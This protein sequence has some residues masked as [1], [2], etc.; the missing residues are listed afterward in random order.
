M[1]KSF[2]AILVFL[3]ALPLAA[4]EGMWLF[5]RTP[6]AFFKQRYGFEP[7]QAWLDHLQKSSIRFNSGGSG[8]FVSADGLALTNHHVGLDCLAK[9]STKTHDYVTT[10]YH[11]KTQADEV[12]CVDLE[13]NVLQSIEDVTARVNAAVTPGMTT[14][15]AQAARRG[16]MSAIEQ[17]SV[18]KSGLRS[19]VVTLFQG[20]EYHLYQYKKYTDVRLVFAPEVAI[21]FFGGDPDNFE[22]PRYD[23]D[24]CFFRAY[25]NNKPVHPKDY[26]K[27]S[28]AGAKDGDLV[29]VSGHPGSTSRLNTMAHLQFFRDIAYPFT[30][31]L[32][33]RREVLLTNYAQRSI[34]NDR[35]AHDELFGVKNS[36]KA[37]LGRI[38][39]LQDPAV[40]QA[41]NATETALRQKVTADAQLNAAYGDA[42][43]N[44]DGA[45]AAYRPIY[46]EYRFV[47]GG[48]AFNSAL[49]QTAKTLLRLA[50]E[51]TK[52]NGERLREYRESNM[53]SLKQQL[54][55]EAPIYEDLE[56]VTL[57]DSL[58]NWLEVAP[59]DPLVQQVLAGKSPQE[60]ASELVRGTKL[61]DVAARKALGEGGKAV[62]DASHDP[63]I[64]VARIVDGRARELRKQYDDNI[65]EVLRQSYAKIA[66]AQFKTSGGDT[67][68]DATFTLRL[69]YGTVKGFEENGKAVPSSTKIGDTFEH[70][71]DHNNEG[72]F[73]LPKSWMA[74]KEVL[75][76]DKTPY[77][78][79]MTADI[80]GGN[81]GSPVVNRKNEFVGIIFDGNIQSLPWDYQFDE[82]QGRAVAV[83][84][85]GILDALRKVYGVTSLVKELT[86]K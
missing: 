74:K 75:D 54:Y 64:E 34:E 16:V 5:N 37:Y 44:V 76:N 14:A 43:K 18:Q 66:N 9:I 13:L 80:I 21:A 10:G 39:G 69:S 33:R 22:Y 57:A 82:R 46:T 78:F 81:S 2:L 3:L 68:P 12:K 85:A 17:E 20:G 47:E 19:D 56:T 36:R 86:G 27:W 35:R 24:V 4:D 52:P 62:V 38:A 7:T 50:D 63:M 65:A 23:L 41:K 11:A 25:E 73:K 45:I 71:A 83:H 32:L 51:S 29:F 26:L 55:S 8:S 58:S 53:P 6:N 60:R 79:V 70:A 84:S 67:Y 31:T 1:R 15:A 77:N 28:E 72:E 30:L 59:N 40:L 49:F 48:L 42:W 61:R